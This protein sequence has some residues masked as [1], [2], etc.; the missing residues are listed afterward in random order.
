MKT[1]TKLIGLGAVALALGIAGYALT[2]SSEEAGPGFGPMFM[3]HGMMNHGMGSMTGAGTAGP[4]MGMGHDSA[5][6]DQLRTIHQ[7]FAS[8]DRI[9]R[10]VT[11]TPDGIRTETTSDDPQVIKWIKTHVAEMGQRVAAGDDPG[12][13]IE[14]DALHAIFRNKD[15][16]RT[17]VETIANGVIVVQTSTDPA[18]V[19]V[20]QEHAAQVT[21]FVKGGMAAMHTAMMSNARGAMHGPMMDGTMMPGRGRM[22]GPTAPGSM[23]HDPN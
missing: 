17:S 21:E 22:H 9:K 23:M 3:R 2:A 20:L 5:T 19:A 13:P 8:H 11:N 10:T 4:F 6:M 18:T 16:I 1:R 12:L 15:K 14:S 7:L